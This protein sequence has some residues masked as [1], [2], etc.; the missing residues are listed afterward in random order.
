MLEGASGFRVR[1]ISSISIIPNFGQCTRLVGL[2][3]LPGLEVHLQT[4]AGLFVGHSVPY[5]YLHGGL[6]TSSS[7]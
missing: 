6:P 3:G 7:L 4:V 1:Q 5:F 2:I